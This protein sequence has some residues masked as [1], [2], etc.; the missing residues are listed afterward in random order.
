[1]TREWV[2]YKITSPTGRIYIGK[3]SQFVKRMNHYRSKKKIESGRIIEKSIAK[4]GFSSHRIEIIESFLDTLNVADS[5]E[6]FWIR[7]YMSNFQ[8]YP[9]QNG[10]NLTDGG[11]GIIGYVRSD[12]SKLKMS[13]I[14]RSNSETMKRAKRMSSDHIGAYK[15]RKRPK[16][17]GIKISAAKS[18]KQLSEKH[19]NSLSAA[20]IGKPS[21]NKRGVLIYDMNGKLVSECGSVRGAAK[22]IGGFNSAIFNVL[23]GTYKQHKGFVLKYK[24]A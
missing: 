7:S 19:R 12:Y 21:N 9:K 3:T 20:K 6:M 15:N 18:G 11:D 22:L 13:N 24:I 10:M 5:K 8:K 14:A 23:N 2:I 1:M 17:I 4:Y 16:Y